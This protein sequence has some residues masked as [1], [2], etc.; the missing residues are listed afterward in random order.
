MDQTI[1][2]KVKLLVELVKH[3]EN[4]ANWYNIC[5]IYKSKGDNTLDNIKW[6]TVKLWKHYSKN[7]AFKFFCSLKL[8]MLKQQ[9]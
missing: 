9:N 1:S 2:V 6:K 8:L 3:Q 7:F 5:N 4:N